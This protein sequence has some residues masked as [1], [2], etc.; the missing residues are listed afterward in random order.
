M[1]RRSSGSDCEALLGF[2]SARKVFGL[3]QLRFE[4]VDTVYPRRRRRIGE[5]DIVPPAGLP[6]AG[7]NQPD[8][9]TGSGHGPGELSSE[10][11]GGTRTVRWDQQKVSGAWVAKLEAREQ[12]IGIRCP[13]AHQAS[14][15]AVKHG[16]AQC[17]L[18]V[19]A[20]THPWIDRIPHKR[21]A[22]RDEQA[23][24]HP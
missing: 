12:Q 24:K 8:S 4:Q 6:A 18:H 19:A 2:Q 10:I 1:L 16:G 11:V 13:T 20:I 22:K 23:E 3:S 9:V 15:E 5:F 14:R 17:L 21:E 7:I